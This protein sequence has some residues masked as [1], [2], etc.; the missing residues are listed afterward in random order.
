MKEKKMEFR[1]DWVGPPK[2]GSRP[3]RNDRPVAGT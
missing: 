1:G 3:H 2:G